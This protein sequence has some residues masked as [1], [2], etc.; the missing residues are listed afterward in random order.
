MSYAN[1]ESGPKRAAVVGPSGVED[2]LPP[3]STALQR[4]LDCGHD[5]ITLYPWNSAD[6]HGRALGKVPRGRW[7]QVDYTDR[8][9]LK[10]VAEG[11][12]TGVRIKDGWVVLDYD[13]RNDPDGLTP[14]MLELEYGSFLESLPGVR[15]GGGGWHRYARVP[16]GSRLRREHPDFPGLEIK[17]EGGQ[18][19][20]AGSRHP[21]GRMYQW[22]EASPRL[23]GDLNTRM[24]LAWRRPKRNQIGHEGPISTTRAKACL[25]QLDV[26]EYRLHDEWFEL[27][28]AFHSATG[29]C[30][31]GRGIFESWSTADPLYSSHTELIR[32]RWDS[33][34]ANK[35][36]GIT[37]G[38]LFHHVRERGGSIPAPDPEEVFDRVPIESHQPEH[39][40]GGIVWAK[41][42]AEQRISWLWR[43]WLARGKA[44]IL[45]G[46]PGLGKTTIALDLFA[47]LST[48]RA[49]PGEEEASHRPTKVLIVAPE[50]TVEDVLRPRLRLADADLGSVGFYEYTKPN[51]IE[52]PVTLSVLGRVLNDAR[53]A[54]VGFV[55]FD[56]I[57]SFIGGNANTH[58]DAGVRE[59]LH[60]ID[61]GVRS[62]GAQFLA[63]RHLHKGEK[64][65]AAFAGGGSIAFTAFARSVLLCAKDPKH[66]DDRNR[67]VLAHT[68][69]NLG[70]SATSLRYRIIEPEPNVTKIEWLATCDLTADELVAYTPDSEK[71]GEA[72]RACGQWLGRYFSDGKREVASNVKAAAR[73]AGHEW[74]NSTWDRARKDRFIGSAG[75]GQ[76]AVW[77][78]EEPRLG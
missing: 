2:P 41:G 78:L 10:N 44:A 19:V 70:P 75:R 37:V 76:T 15:T 47:R 68:K 17:Q 67:G 53:K 77:F 45:E 35:A 20:A 34:E 4:H 71:R 32:E 28:T 64:S 66:W 69:G 5:L 46:N 16:E 27:M 39:G 25:D 61:C 36:G 30:L 23:A 29:G 14:D 21:N 6:A 49:F 3:F 8:D 26:L 74:T 60:E 42:I 58:N 18:V 48:G 54:G 51:G 72:R 52:V 13:P 1:F 9:I 31:E 40:S 62:I 55:Y 57:M 22:I 59:V 63:T 56:S 43:P 33:L 73:A 12:N 11:G 50:D 24:L 38:T 65:I 7:R